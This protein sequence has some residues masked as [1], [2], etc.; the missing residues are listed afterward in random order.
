MGATNN[1]GKVA[2]GHGRATANSCFLPPIKDN[3]RLVFPTG[4]CV[5][6]PVTNTTFGILSNENSCHGTGAGFPVHSV[7]FATLFRGA[8]CGYFATL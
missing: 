5:D 3:L 8:G 1:G 7:E 4:K 6:D 2:F